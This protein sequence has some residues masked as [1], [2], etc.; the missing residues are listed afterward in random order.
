M[1]V[2]KLASTTDVEAALGRDL[3]TSE[4]SKVGAILDK[5]SELFRSRSG[6]QFT[7]GTS[8]VR[9]KVTADW[10]S[11]P[12]RPVVSVESVTVDEVSGAA[13]VFVLYQSRLTLTN[14]EAGDMV[15]VAYTHGGTVPDLVRLTV[16]DIARKILSIDENAIAGL[17]QHSETVG[18]FTEQDTYA[19]WAQG[20]QTMLSPSDNAVADTFRVR[21]YGSI[22]MTP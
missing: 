19:T 11:L 13:I 21:S 9:L 5:A 15:R 4:T 3:T 18:P 6:Q 10:V 2:T 22:V 16:A 7:A 20:G 17:T 1:A 14:V 12:Q 8:E